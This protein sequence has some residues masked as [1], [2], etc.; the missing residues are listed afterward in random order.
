MPVQYSYEAVHCYLM[1]LAAFYVE[2]VKQKSE[3]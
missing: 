3:A 1:M 2:D